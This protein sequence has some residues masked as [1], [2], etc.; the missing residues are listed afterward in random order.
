[1]IDRSSYNISLMKIF[2]Y[3]NKEIRKLYLDGSA[4]LI[5]FGSLLMLPAGK[6][7]I[8][9]IYPA[10]IFNIACGGDLSWSPILYSVV[11]IGI[12]LC[13]FLIRTLLLAKLKEL[14]PAQVLRAKE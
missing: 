8:D 3:R 2:G 1:M 7:L 11:Y 4:Y 14:T 5:A 10:F 12:L 13:Y 6:I 9:L